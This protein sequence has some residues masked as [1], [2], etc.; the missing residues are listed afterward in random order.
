MAKLTKMVSAIGSLKDLN[1]ARAEFDDASKTIPAE[2]A[3]PPAEIRPPVDNSRTLML[4]VTNPGNLAEV[5]PQPSSQGDTFAVIHV[6]ATGDFAAALVLNPSTQIEAG[7]TFA[8]IADEGGWPVVVAMVEE[9]LGVRIDHIAQLDADALGRVIDELGGL[10]VYSRA[11]F[12]ADGTDFVEGTNNLDGATS[13][14]FTAAD[15][16]DDAGQTRTRNQRAVVR[17]LVQGI[18]SGGLVKDPNKGAAVLG[19]YA[20]G[21]QHNAE[22]TTGE[23]VKIANGL[24]AL[25]NDD[26]AVVTVPTNSRREDDGTVIIDFDPEAMP[27]L[28]NALAGNDLADLFRYLGSLGY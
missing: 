21:I 3:F 1:A 10:Q 5:A 6:P 22:L 4:R 13:A 27:A 23:L 16:V 9:F 11:A 18:K 7:Q 15:P 2:A 25:Q 19:H 17:A 26:I 28:K 24:R 20:S 8:T 14:I 12:N